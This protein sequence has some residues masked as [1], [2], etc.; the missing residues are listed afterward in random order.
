[1]SR[2][3]IS[4]L[5]VLALVGMTAAATPALARG[6]CKHVFV[7]A[8]NKTGKTVKVIDMDYMISGYGLRSEPVKNQVI[9]VGGVWSITHNLEHANER[10]TQIIVKYRVQRRTHGLF[11]WSHVFKQKSSYQQCK[12]GRSYS[13][14]LTQR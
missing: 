5:T 14:V 11:Q 4:A 2:K 3:T 13:V 10:N 9:P 7:Q 12:M 6:N 1:V 8:T